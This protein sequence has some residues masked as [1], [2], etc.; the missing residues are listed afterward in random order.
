MR[1][2]NLWVLPNSG[3]DT[4]P[5]L[6]EH[7][8]AFHRE[9]P[10]IKVNIAV[11]TP[12]SLWDRLIAAAKEGG[13]GPDVVQL[14][15]YWTSTLA[16]LGALADL[17]E[18]D[19]VLDLARWPASL[20]AQCRLDG[21]PRVHSLPWW[22]EARI[23]YY[24]RDVLAQAGVAPASLATWD[25]FKDACRRISKKGLSVAG[26]QHPVA[27]PN[28]RESVA[29]ADVAPCVWSRGGD[30]FAADG[31]RS[32]FQRERAQRGISDYFQL[33]SSGAMPLKGE[34]GLAP[35]DL[36]EGACALQFSGRRPPPVPRRGPKRLL[37]RR[38]RRHVAAAP[39][40][41]GDGTTLL[42]AWNLGVARS[43]DVPREAFAL[44]RW[45]VGGAASASYA[46]A[47]GA[48]PAAE[49]AAI[50]G[51]EDPELRDVFEEAFSRARL[52][53]NLSVL[54]S[55]ERVFERGMERL[56]RDVARRRWT[57]EALRTELIHAASEVDYILS[58]YAS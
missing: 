20:R 19:P 55:L 43:T 34:S 44:L 57:P 32:L 6:R 14:P 12:R 1:E 40:P 58:F 51:P 23:L 46:Q 49:G 37:A 22:V 39:F 10:G 15:S 54:G 31:T 3:Y 50:F 8:Y 4:V 24:R 41:S 47:I 28:P 9:H 53:P 16:R 27:N 25:G 2:L 26:L 18:L 52:I 7:L 38:A 30:L 21:T 5:S 48:F 56:V 11:R 42:S 29:L 45:L 13:K 36:F 17:G 35:L 33:L